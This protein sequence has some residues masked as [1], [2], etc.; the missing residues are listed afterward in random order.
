MH[1]P[2]PDETLKELFSEEA[3]EETNITL[4]S[5]QHPLILVDA[6]RNDIMTTTPTSSRIT[7]RFIDLC[8]VCTRPIR[9]T[10]PFYKCTHTC[11]FVLHPWC[12]R[13]PAEI[14][15]YHKDRFDPEHTLLL[16]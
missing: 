11:D 8:N 3:Y 16:Y 4:K 9:D 2:P 10:M 13:L 12:T 7:N 5:H 6:E 14:K 15:G 1:L